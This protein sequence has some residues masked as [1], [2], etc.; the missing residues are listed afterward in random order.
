M[1]RL[2]RVRPYEDPGF[3]RVR[4]GGGFRYVDHAGG[5]VAA[6]DADRART[7]VIPPAWREVWISHEPLAHIQAVGTDEAG[8][9]QYL[10][11]ADWSKRQ[12]K[13]KFARALALADTLP[14]ARGRV[15]QS[16]RRP[17]LDRERVLAV[18]FRLLDQ[19]APRVGSARYFT[20]NGSRGLTTLQRRDATVEGSHVELSF[21]AKSGKRAYLELDDDDLAAA[22]GELAAGRPR[23]PLLT[24]RRGRR[25][26]ALRPGDV[27]AYVRVLTGGS[28][29]AKDFR[30]LRG[31]VLAA[32]ALARIGTV[33]TASERKRAEL[34]AI[35]ATAE[36][37]GNT[38]AV[39][40]SSY[41]D[42]RVFDRYRKGTLLNLEGSRDN[43]IRALI[44][45]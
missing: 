30:T 29:S 10:Y 43:A 37:L 27:N 26:V 5:A 2:L 6:H 44:L 23:A 19:V 38:P 9:R 31:T 15:T 24:Y 32:E 36:G 13:G 7:L 1:A 25:R 16:L 20:T 39:A 12:D 34:L 28:F 11:H 45:G 4:S 3:R 17:E 22:L 33:D 42:P 14:R 18:S 21:P 41:I 8:R 35:R 40:K